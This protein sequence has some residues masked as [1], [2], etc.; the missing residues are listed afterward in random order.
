M[1]VIGG[2]FM[3]VC[4]IVYTPDITVNHC[5][6]TIV[7]MLEPIERVFSMWPWYIGYVFSKYALDSCVSVLRTKI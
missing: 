3:V 7:H 4:T 2:I 6:C 5:G 1:A